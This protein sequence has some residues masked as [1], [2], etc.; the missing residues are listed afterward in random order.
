MNNNELGKPEEVAPGIE[1]LD[2]GDND[3]ECVKVSGDELVKYANEPKDKDGIV[4]RLRTLFKEA[5]DVDSGV[6]YLYR[7]VLSS[8]IDKPDY[9]QLKEVPSDKRMDDLY[10]QVKSL[11]GEFASPEEGIQL[12]KTVGNINPDDITKHMEEAKKL[13]DKKGD[14]GLSSGTTVQ[15]VK[16]TKTN[17]DGKKEPVT[18]IKA[19][20]GGAKA[21][22]EPVSYYKIKEGTDVRDV[23]DQIQEKGKPNGTDGVDYNKVKG[24]E[25]PE[26]KKLFEGSEN[27]P[28]TYY[29]TTNVKGSGVDKYGKPYGDGKVHSVTVIS[30]PENKTNKPYKVEQVFRK[31]EEANDKKEREKDK[32]KYYYIKLLG[33]KANKEAKEPLAKTTGDTDITD[34]YNKL[35]GDMAYRPGMGDENDAVLLIKSKTDKTDKAILDSVKP[36]L[37]ESKPRKAPKRDLEREP[38]YPAYPE[39]VAPEKARPGLETYDVGDDKVKCVKITGRSIN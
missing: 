13:Y 36:K 30:D 16:V 3:L 29:Y 38:T 26:V 10:D 5:N 23:L 34:V 9:S 33:A 21:G 12:V 24:D 4:L 14:D 25:L 27:M 2:V 1:K 17:K 28:K 19:V 6:N 37:R 22:E 39:E 7:K 8:G 20:K 11:L 35:K 15:C 31:A 32:A 18:Y